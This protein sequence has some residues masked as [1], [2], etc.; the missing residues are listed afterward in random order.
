MASNDRAQR[1]GIWIIAIVMTI[2]TLGSFAVI[3]LQ[4]D[5]QKIDQAAAQTAAD[6]QQKAALATA[7][8]QA[9]SSEPL[10]GY[11]ARQFDPAAVTALKVDM[12]K[13]GT[14]EAV[15]ATDSINA[16]YFGWTSD[17]VIFDSSK[18]KDKADAPVT[19]PLSN[20]ISGWTEGL[21]GVKVGSTVRLTIPSAK[22]YG[23]TGQGPIAANSPLEFIVT[24]N[25]IDNTTKATQ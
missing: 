3:I 11:S 1:I 10:L 9:K 24:I 15:K 16:S 17:G 20:V 6:E 18:K 19:F 21:T 22:A 14:G 2:G 23:A 4:N 12:L 7:K 5:N 13:E 8:E 25:K